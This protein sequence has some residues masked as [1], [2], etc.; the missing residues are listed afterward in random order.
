MNKKGEV[1]YFFYFVNFGEQRRVAKKALR[2][3][4]QASITN[5]AL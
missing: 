2:S 5:R 4:P 1:F 3:H